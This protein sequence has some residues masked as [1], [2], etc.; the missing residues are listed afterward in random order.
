MKRRIPVTLTLA[1]T[2]ASACSPPEPLAPTQAAIVNGTRERGEPWVVA[3]Y[4]AAGGSTTGGLC[5][6]SVIGPF[7][8][9]TAKHCVFDRSG[10]G[11]TM[12]SPTSFTV[13]VG[14]DLNDAGA[15]ETT[16]RVLEIRTTPGSNVDADIE[17]GNDIAVLLLD[18]RLEVAPRAVSR[19]AP[20]TGDALRIIGFGRTRPGMGTEED[21]GVKYAGEAAVSRVGSR[22]FESTGRSWTCQGDSGGPALH[23]GRGEILGITSYG[24]SGCTVSNSYYT[25]VDRHLPLVDE[26]LRFE[27]P[28]VPSAERCNGVD[29]D[30]DGVVDSGCTPLGEPCTSDAECAMGRCDRVGGRRVCVRDCDPREAIARCPVGFHCEATG[31]ACGQGRCVAG[32]PGGAQDGSLCASNLDCASARCVE[33]AGQ[34]RCARVCSPDETVCASGTVCDAPTGDCGSCVPVELSTSPRPFGAP[35]LRADQCRSGL[36]ENGQCTRACDE[37]APCPDGYRCRGGRCVPGAPG[38]PGAACEGDE[39]CGAAAPRCVEVDGERLCA[40]PCSP[41]VDEACGLGLECLDGHCVRP[42]AGLGSACS[43][44]EECR[45]GLCAGLCTRLC[46]PTMPCPSGFECTMA[47]GSTLAGCFPPGYLE[48]RRTR[49]SSGGCSVWRVSS[50]RGGLA[51]TLALALLL[52]GSCRRSVR[53]GKKSGCQ[54]GHR[55]ATVLGRELRPRLGFGPRYESVSVW[56]SGAV[57]GTASAPESSRAPLDALDRRGQPPEVSGPVRLSP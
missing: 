52:V 42:G 36:C 8:V 19:A 18:A 50:R 40:R 10:R 11:W 21:A 44:N 20:R 43:A 24:V 1:V 47:E 26:A 30:C 34:R 13:F 27:P 31:P 23:A 37:R 29:D 25:R 51:A 5:T 28:C 22:V 55:A 32:E 48:P 17:A 14:H 53:L 41:G 4:H 39:D 2:F 7:A 56:R 3:V 9:L 12:A 45:S 46:G 15:I 49:G 6:G 16:R 57:Q 38:G 54:A 35:C 33:I